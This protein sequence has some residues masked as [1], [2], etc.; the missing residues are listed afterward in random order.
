MTSNHYSY[1]TGKY[2][3]TAARVMGWIT[4][5]FGLLTIL[6]GSYSAWLLLPVGVVVHYAHYRT[7][8]D[9]ENMLYREGVGLGKFVIGKKLPLT[10][11]DFLFL[12]HNRYSQ[13]FESRASM[14][15]IKLEKYDGYLKLAD[16]VKLHLL[17]HK[18]KE[19]AMAKMQAIARDLNVE[20][21]DL[22][23][24]KYY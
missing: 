17:Q 14:T 7:E 5:V 22:T 20:L 10:G 6:D 11:F 24:M 18:E 21:R 23:N 2:F 3:G 9:L 8:F 1:N 16:G 13:T 15:S 12:K 19:K 4:S